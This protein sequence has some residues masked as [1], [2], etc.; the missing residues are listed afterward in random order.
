MI[1]IR[2]IF[3]VAQNWRGSN[4]KNSDRSC[5]LGAFSF[6]L[7]LLKGIKDILRKRLSAYN[8]RSSNATD[9]LPPLKK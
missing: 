5:L 8:K 4:G 6:S 7:R 3:M 1:F 9:F 2:H